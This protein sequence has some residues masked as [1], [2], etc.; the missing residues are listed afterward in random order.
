M[1][2][3]D[4]KKMMYEGMVEAFKKDG[5]L[6]PICFFLKDNTPIIVQLPDNAMADYESKSKLALVIKNMCM[7]EGVT[8]A[9]LV[10]EAYAAK[11]D[12]D[13]EMGNLVQNGSV[14]VS[15][16]KNK[17]NIIFMVFSTP[18]KE[19]MIAHYVDC[20]KQE[21]GEKMESMEQFKGVFSGFFFWTKN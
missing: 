3:K 10:T 11:F 17:E 19:E 15:E 5:F 8:A 20:D 21:V 14:R 16:C 2:T 7:E 9:G 4:F 1:D 18:H 13:D 12:K 6:I